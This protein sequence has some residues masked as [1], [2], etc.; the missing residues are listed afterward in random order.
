[1]KPERDRGTVHRH[2]RRRAIDPLPGGRRPGGLHPPSAGAR[3]RTRGSGRGGVGATV[4]S[5]PDARELRE[6]CSLPTEAAL[7]R[8]VPFLEGLVE[9]PAFLGGDILP[10]LEEAEGAENWYVARR[11]EEAGAYSL[12]TFVWPAGTGTMIH[13]H[14][15]WGAY[16]CVVGSVL[17]TR[18]ERLDDGS[19]A[20]HA[21]LKRSWQLRWG[22]EDG[23]STVLPGDG[24]IH[25][26]ANPGGGPSVSVHLYGP[27]TAQIDG[28]D[29]DPS[30]DY[31]C[32]RLED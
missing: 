12:Q 16:R 1:M 14:S 10:L 18:Y 29:Y 17:E 15:S 19:R 9:D 20:G 21:R 30:R 3:T 11:Y 32:D 7:R 23:A 6:I 28:R 5:A 8:A 25:S 27:R 31:V 24:G 4:P 13:D 22:P 2:G 26:V